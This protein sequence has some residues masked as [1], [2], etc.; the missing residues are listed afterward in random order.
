MQ[1]LKISSS[2]PHSLLFPSLQ[3]SMCLSVYHFSFIYGLFGLDSFWVKE[4]SHPVYMSQILDK[5]SNKIKYQHML[6][7]SIK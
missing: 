5:N 1:T 3:L 2:Q 6:T 7:S 4:D